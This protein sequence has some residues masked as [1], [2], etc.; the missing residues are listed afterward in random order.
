MTVPD[1]EATVTVPEIE[2]SMTLPETDLWKYL[3][4]ESLKGRPVVI[5]GTGNGADKIIRYLEEYGVRTAGIF[6]SPGFV[7]DRYF[8]GMKVEDFD[9]C[10][11]RFGEKMIT[12]LGFG[13]SRQEVIDYTE[14]IRSRCEFYVPDVPVYGDNLFDLDFCRKHQTELDRVRKLLS[15]DLSVK[16]FDAVIRT[17]LSGDCRILREF[18]VLP[19]EADSLIPEDKEGILMD[20]GA[21]NGDTVLRYTG[22]L[23]GIS[24]IIAVEP[25]RRNMRKLRENT[26]ELASGIDIE[27]VE[28]FVSDRKG[29]VAAGRNL[30]RGNAINKGNTGSFREINTVTIDGLIADRKEKAGFI[31]FDVEGQESAAIR[32]GTYTIEEHKPEM[33]VAC[34]HRSED[35]FDIPMKVLD[36]NP[37]Y[38]VF[39][40]HERSLQ[41]W[42]TNYYFVM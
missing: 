15:D 33:C 19:Q 17:R 41:T 38:K 40:R 8:H 39:M 31:K 6:A 36:L 21:Y 26:S 25:D 3:Q 27:Y 22:R 1:I 16:T 24:G 29:T 37:D 13:S 12:L 11:K 7:R 9:S 10:L 14:H 28:G 5:Y 42:D 23:H 32:G 4:A 18:E 34:Y 35:L 30:G 20:L 2:A